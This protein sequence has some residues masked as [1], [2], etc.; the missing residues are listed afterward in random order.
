MSKSNFWWGFYKLADCKDVQKGRASPQGRR[1]VFR[2]SW[3]KG[4]RVAE[5]AVRY[6]WKLFVGGRASGWGWRNLWRGQAGCRGRRIGSDYRW[7]RRAMEQG[8]QSGF[9]SCQVG[10]AGAWS[11]DGWRRSELRWRR[12]G[13][14]TWTEL[15][16]FTNVD[17][18][19]GVLV[20]GVVIVSGSSRKN[21]PNDRA[22]FKRWSHHLW[23]VVWGGKDIA[24]VWGNS[25][26]KREWVNVHSSRFV[27]VT[28]C[29]E[30]CRAEN[31]SPRTGEV[32]GKGVTIG[33]VVVAGLIAV[34]TC[35]LFSVSR[36]QN[37]LKNRKFLFPDYIAQKRDILHLSLNTWKIENQ[38]SEVRSQKKGEEI[39]CVREKRFFF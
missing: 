3:G 18:R 38:K 39:V 26:Q 17:A 27:G 21:N 25:K 2:W 11:C 23:V 7:R 20:I 5:A 37:W 32:A 9:G 16:R 15:Q 29:G 4:R 33:L 12:E 1:K 22:T 14:W 13:S 8:V 36:P 30:W 28:T 34:T 10:H 35:G 19:V 24:M 31:T 6:P